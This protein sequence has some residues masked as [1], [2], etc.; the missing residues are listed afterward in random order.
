VPP[1]GRINDGNRV[2]TRRFHP[3]GTAKGDPW[4]HTV[5]EI[6]ASDGSVVQ[7]IPG[8]KG[9]VAIFPDGSQARVGNTQTGTI[10]E[11][12]AQGR[13]RPIRWPR[14]PQDQVWC[15]WEQGDRTISR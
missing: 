3:G 12:N 14:L 15:L 4:N 13:G 8:F 2:A 7:N 9:P 5:T 11:L 6:N 1:R 10:T